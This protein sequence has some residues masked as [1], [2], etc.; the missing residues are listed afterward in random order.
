[1]ITMVNTAWFRVMVAASLFIV[2]GCGE[3]DDIRTPSVVDDVEY[4]G[5]CGNETLVVGSSTFYPLLPDERDAL[6]NAK[7]PLNRPNGLV[8]GIGGG[9][10]VVPPGPGDDIGTLTVYNDGIARFQSDSGRTIW[11]ST[12][13]RTYDW[14]C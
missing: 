6:D 4:Y 3:D 11:L 13:Q 2:P 14:D 10:R 1:M 12:D 8:S 9:L 5:A 7:Y